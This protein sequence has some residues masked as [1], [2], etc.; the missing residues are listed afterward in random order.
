MWILEPWLKTETS[1]CRYWTRGDEQVTAI[2]IT[3]RRW[4]Y[5]GDEPPVRVRCFRRPDESRQEDDIVEPDAEHRAQSVAEAMAWADGWLS[6]CD[7]QGAC[8]VPLCR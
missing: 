6:S 1:A 2:G 7:M 8:H 5:A 4:W 3:D